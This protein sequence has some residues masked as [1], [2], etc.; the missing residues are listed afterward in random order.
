V[1]ARSHNLLGV[2]YKMLGE[3]ALSLQHQEQALALFRQVGDER[4]VAG[5]LS[6]LGE[7]AR[8]RGDFAAAIG[9]Y[10]QAL[11]AAETIGDRDWEMA[12]RS[13][14]GAAQV[15]LGVYDAAE[16]ELRQAIHMAERGGEPALSETYSFLAEA[17]LGLGKVDEALAAAE[18]AL[19]LGQAAGHQLFTGI[20][21]RVLGQVA[22]RTGEPV[23]AGDKA[24][25]ATACFAESLR[26]FRELGA[27]GEEVR[28]LEL[29]AMGAPETLPSL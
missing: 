5:M 22:V 16:V 19:A 3:Y 28:T 4:R 8:Q 1:L 17:C 2:T 21:W 15:G 25:G 13:N 24:H 7:T 11:T 18:R 9:L 23:A 29:W 26:I 10:Y 27:E 12:F 20:A 6:N 14:L